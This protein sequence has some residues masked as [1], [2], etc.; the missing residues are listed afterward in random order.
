[1]E[2]HDTLAF[3][4]GSWHV[5]RSIDDRH[6]ATTGTFVG[7]S[8]LVPIASLTAHGVVQRATYEERGE[9]QLGDHA[10]SARRGLEYRRKQDGSVALYFL[11]GRHFVDLDL[12][13]GRCE[14]AHHCASDIYSIEFVAS[15]MHRYTEHWRVVGP[16]KD[17]EALTVYSRVSGD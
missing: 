10:G 3:L 14:G 6:S 9:L 15:S 5:E 13:S 17:Y 11:D 7:A 4:I 12:S 8:R 16:D 2:I 1:M